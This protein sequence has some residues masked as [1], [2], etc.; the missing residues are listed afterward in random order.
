ML[1]RQR[2][3]AVAGV[4]DDRIER[5]LERV[6]RLLPREAARPA[7]REHDAARLQHGRGVDD[8]PEAVLLRRPA[9]TVVEAERARADQVADRQ[10]SFRDPLGDACDGGVA[11]RGLE[12]GERDTDVVDARGGPERERAVEVPPHRADAADRD[13]RMPDH[14]SRGR[15]RAP[16][17]CPRR[18]AA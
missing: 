6:G 9:T 7:G 12:L 8:P 17:C 16:P 3:P 10:H 11:A 4:G 5:V 2:H 1:Q 13:A 15:G 18:P 14:V